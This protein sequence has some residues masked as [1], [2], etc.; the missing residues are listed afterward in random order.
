MTWRSR[1]AEARALLVERHGLHLT[2]DQ[3]AS[4]VERTQG[5]PAM[6]VLAG[7]WLRG[8]DDLAVR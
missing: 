8:V 7:I 3:V 1:K 4:L 6:L 2:S 5:W